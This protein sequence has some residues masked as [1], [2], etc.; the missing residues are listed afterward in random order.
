MENTLPTGPGR[1]S[2]TNS[3]PRSGPLQGPGSLPFRQTS[4]LRCRQSDSGTPKCRLFRYE[5]N[6]EVHEP[7][8]VAEKRRRYAAHGTPSA[9]NG[10]NTDR[11][12]PV[13]PFIGTT[14]I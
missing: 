13:V 3:G 8:L 12:R 7:Q 4:K 14:T 11:W 2:T 1:R 9:Y 10:G 5:K 6:P